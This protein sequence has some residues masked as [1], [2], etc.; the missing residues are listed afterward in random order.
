MKTCKV[1]GTTNAAARW[2]MQGGKP[3]GLVCHACRLALQT[4]ARSTEESRVKARVIANIANKKVRSTAEGRA[5]SNAASLASYKKFTATAEG[6]AKSN[7][8]SNLRSLKW[9]RVNS[10]KV[11]AK[12]GKRRA[13]RLQCTP[14]WLTKSDLQLIEAKYAM[15]RWLSEVV[16]VPYHVDHSIPLQ[17]ALVSGLHVPD[18]LC[19]LRGVDNLS[20]NN[21]YVVL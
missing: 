6:R 14:Q 12:N 5:K 3:S 4:L 9:A 19:V 17:G 21:K 16:G 10:D 1:C 20:K 8:D 15:A 2:V 13:A 7:A 11:N 18:N